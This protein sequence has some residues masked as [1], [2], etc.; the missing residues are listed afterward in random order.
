[1]ESTSSYVVLLFVDYY[2]LAKPTHLQDVE[3]D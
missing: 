3:L 1:M 2:Q